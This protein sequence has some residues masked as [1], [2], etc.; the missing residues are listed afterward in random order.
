MVGGFEGVAV[1]LELGEFAPGFVAV[2]LVGGAVAG[3][4]AEVAKRTQGGVKCL[5]NFELLGDLEL[6]AGVDEGL[7]GGFFLGTGGGQELV[8]VV[9]AE[10]LVGG[11][12]AAGESVG[13]G[14]LGGAGFAGGGFG[15][16]GAGAV[17]AGLEGAF[18]AGFFIDNFGHCTSILTGGLVIS[19]VE[20]AW[21]KAGSGWW[22]WG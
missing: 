12:V 22:D 1:V 3:V 21:K 5:K 20:R 19:G 2:A 14:V 10:G 11:G 8:F 16:A 18:L 13:A 7:E 6:V 15:A 9:A 17:A 4:E